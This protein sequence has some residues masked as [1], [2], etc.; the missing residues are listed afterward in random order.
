MKMILKSLKKDQKGFSLIEL[1][2]VVA[3]IG[4]LAAVAVP[5]FTQFQRKA[6][7]SEARGLLTSAFMANKAFFAEYNQYN[8]DFV[9]VGFKPEGNLKYRVTIAAAATGYPTTYPPA[10]RPNAMNSATYC[11]LA[12]AA[13]GGTC[14]MDGSAP[15]ADWQ[16]ASINNAAGNQTFNFVAT[17]TIG[18]AA[19]DGW[20]INQNKALL[21]GQIGL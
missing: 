14:T 5:N 10:P 9:A 18:G 7:Q 19:N 20:N 17:G 8:S 12:V 11:A 15:G 6:R 1:M 16:A 4:I 3:I 13:G 21:N 2:I